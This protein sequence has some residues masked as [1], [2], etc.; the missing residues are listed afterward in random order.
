MVATSLTVTNSVTFKILLSAACCSISFSDCS[1]C[2]SLLDLRCFAP[3]PFLVL[4]CRRS[5]VSRTCFW[6]SSSVG[7]TF[8][9]ALPLPLGCLLL[10]SVV[11]LLNLLKALPPPGLLIRLRFVL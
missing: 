5:N 11:F 2:K 10:L 6:I 4:P 8:V 1:V 7:S 9:T 3:L